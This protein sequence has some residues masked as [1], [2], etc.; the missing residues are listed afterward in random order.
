MGD[1]NWGKEGCCA[2]RAAGRM[3]RRSSERMTA[4][5]R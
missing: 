1:A 4:R 5:R 2:A 3:N